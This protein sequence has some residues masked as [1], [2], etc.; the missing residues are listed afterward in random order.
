VINI[1]DNDNDLKCFGALLDSLCIWHG[2]H[3]HANM[4]LIHKLSK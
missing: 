1:N 4:E 2:R 3:M